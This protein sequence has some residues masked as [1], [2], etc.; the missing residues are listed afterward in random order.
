[1]GRKH[2]AGAVR[3]PGIRGTA[4]GF[5]RH[6]VTTIG[7]RAA[8]GGGGGGSG[9]GSSSSSRAALAPS[10]GRH[11]PSAKARRKASGTQMR[12]G[13]GLTKGFQLKIKHG[14]EVKI[15]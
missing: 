1:V 15:I 11:A 14:K 4:D 12:K 5:G 10:V 13:D 9:S 3:L 6:K 8:G 7:A 2:G